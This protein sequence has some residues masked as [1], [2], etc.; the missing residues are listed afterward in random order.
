[1][2]AH[3][4]PFQVYLVL[5]AVLSLG[6]G[7][8]AHFQFGL[9]WILAWLLGCN[10]AAFPLWAWDKR[11]ARTG[12]GRVPEN[13]LHTMAALGATPASFLAMNLLRHKTQKRVFGVLYTVFLVVQTGLAIWWF[14]RGGA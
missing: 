11:R 14:G 10:L 9:D 1:M 5:F 2:S 6:L 13:V 7:A 12:G 4:N 3:R 8:V